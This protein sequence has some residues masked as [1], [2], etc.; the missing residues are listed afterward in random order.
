MKWTGSGTATFAPLCSVW[1]YIGPPGGADNSELAIYPTRIAA[2]ILPKAALLDAYTKFTGT[3]LAGAGDEEDTI[4]V[5]LDCDDP[6]N[7]VNIGLLSLDSFRL[8]PLVI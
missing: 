5:E 2:G 8:A 7:T 6:A 4:M 1:F 3:Y